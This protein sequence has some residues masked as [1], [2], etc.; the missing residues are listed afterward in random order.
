M[1]IS[2]SNFAGAAPSCTPPP[3]LIMFCSKQ[4]PIL[5][6]KLDPA[7]PH[8]ELSQLELGRFEIFNSRFIKKKWINRTY[9]FF[10]SVN[11]FWSAKFFCTY[12]KTTILWTKLRLP[13]RRGGGGGGQKDYTR[14]LVI[15]YR[16]TTNKFWRR[17][18][19]SLRISK[20]WFIII[21]PSKL[22]HLPRLQFK[23]NNNF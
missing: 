18:L 23:E 19:Y 4:Y 21:S 15:D 8:Y 10:G 16:K 12:A 5:F 9:R 1:L 13:R 6:K 2:F 7:L 3:S 11:S 22:K 14:V 17:K 20:M